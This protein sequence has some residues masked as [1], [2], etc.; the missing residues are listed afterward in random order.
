[1]KY[2]ITPFLSL[3][4]KGTEAVEFYCKHLGAKVLFMATYKDMEKMDS[5]FTSPKG[6]EGYIS[7]AIIAAGGSQLLLSDD[8][9]DGGKDLRVG[10]NASICIQSNDMDSIQRIYKSLT[11]SDKVKIVV[12]LAP[13]AFSPAYAI[14]IDPYGL[15]IQLN[16]ERNR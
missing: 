1:M 8:F 14:V 2:S 5:S 4:G 6:K 9:M 11:T 12:P 3:A 15:I 13:S 7:H 10:N 16:V